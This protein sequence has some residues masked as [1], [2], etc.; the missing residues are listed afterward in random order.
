MIIAPLSKSALGRV[1]CSM[2]V[3]IP[4]SGSDI[5][6]VVVVGREYRYGTAA[7]E[8]CMLSACQ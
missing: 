7:T 2:V 8:P 1:L 4:L 3:E 5:T 6:A